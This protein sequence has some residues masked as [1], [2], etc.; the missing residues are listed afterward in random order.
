M[1]VTSSQTD[2]FPNTS[3]T[4]DLSHALGR[5]QKGVIESHKNLQPNIIIFTWKQKEPDIVMDWQL[6]VGQK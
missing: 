6:T 1:T 2:L 3:Y 5:G 4:G